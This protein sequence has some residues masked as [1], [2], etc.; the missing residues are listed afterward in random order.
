M[1]RVFSAA[2]SPNPA[3]FNSFLPARRARRFPS[4]D[5][6]V[7]DLIGMPV[8]PIPIST[9]VVLTNPIEVF[10]AAV[11]FAKPHAIGLIFAG[12]PMMLVSMV[13]IV[14]DTIVRAESGRKQAH[15]RD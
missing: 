11:T 3:A 9:T 14:V 12:V 8:T 7:E 10:V 15:R 13:P 4:A 2:G 5:V 6:D 1:G